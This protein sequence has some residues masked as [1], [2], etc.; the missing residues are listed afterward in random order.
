MRI[1]LCSYAFAPNL[2]GIET[3]SKILAEQ[4]CRLGS[5]VTVATY[6]PG[7]RVEAEYEV[8]RRPGFG[9]LY[10]LARHADISFQNNISLN[11]LPP[12]FAARKPVVVAHHTWIART[13]GRR[14]WQDHLKLGVI[15]GCHNI[16]ISRAMAASLPGKSTI[17]GDPFEPQEFRDLG[18]DFRTK[19][20][21]FVGRLVSDKG[22]DLALR[23]L[24]ILKAQGLRPSFTVVG[25]GPEGPAL[26]RLAGE[27][28]LNEQVTFLGAM[29]EGRGEEVARHRVMVVP[30]LWAEPFGVVV[31][32]GLAAGCALAASA[33]GGLPD[34]VGPCGLLFP[35]GDAQAL[36]AALRDL[37]ADAG[38]RT[39]LLAGRNRH[40]EQ[41]RPEQVAQ[42]YLAVFESALRQR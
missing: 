36:A 12:L 39:K 31:L 15:R 40:L 27:L 25:D 42:R 41:F 30:S 7:E 14:G 20:I 23:S 9:Q 26:K 17:I 4:F 1:L 19:D 5:T 34:A 24:G 37:L 22:C 3:V 6:T 16:A 13:D 35:N 11:M 18:E 2:G 8:V 38:L 29:R 28:G 21:V 32:E 10:D 33:D